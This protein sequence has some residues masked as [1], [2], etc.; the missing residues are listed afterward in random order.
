MGKC[1]MKTLWRAGIR[2][3]MGIPSFTF[4]RVGHQG[5]WRRRRR[6]Y[7]GNI[8][9]NQLFLGGITMDFRR[10]AN[11]MSNYDYS[12]DGLYFVTVCT[13]ERRA[14]LGEVINTDYQTGAY[15]RLTEEG[16]LVN[17]AICRLPEV[18]DGIK[19]HHFVVMPNH[20]H[21]LIELKG[22]SISLSSILNYYKGYVTRRCGRTI[23]QK[24]F[25]DHVVRNEKEYRRIWEYICRIACP[26]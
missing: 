17:A 14:L 4:L 21:L 6:R 26:V 7:I 2:V 18:F 11:R 16:V 25:Y 5:P 15:V 9:N 3:K 10:R 8:I 24:S 20:I 12:E 13:Y 1:E 19:I 23:W 22:A